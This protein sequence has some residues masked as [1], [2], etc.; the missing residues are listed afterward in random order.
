MQ[1]I[2]DHAKGFLQVMRGDIGKLLE[3]LVGTVEV[4]GPRPDPPFQGGCG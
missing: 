4:F 2:R 1:I 3:L